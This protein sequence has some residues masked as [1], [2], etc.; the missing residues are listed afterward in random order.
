MYATIAIYSLV[1]F[2]LLIVVYR[3]SPLCD[4]QKQYR[5][6]ETARTQIRIGLLEGK[7]AKEKFRFSCQKGEIRIRYNYSRSGF[8]LA[9]KFRFR[10]DPDSDPRHC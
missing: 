2:Q 6:Y 4:F 9:I 7:I 10:L 3:Y 1:F 8:D 5:T